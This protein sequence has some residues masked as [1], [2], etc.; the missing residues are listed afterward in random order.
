MT[1]L[2]LVFQKIQSEDKAKY[3]NSYFLSSKA[4]MIINEIYIDDV[5]RSIYTTLITKRFSLDY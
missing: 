1:T 3:D 2:V 4:E 5:F